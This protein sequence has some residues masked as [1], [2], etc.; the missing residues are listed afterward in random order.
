MMS[1]FVRKLYSTLSDSV[2]YHIGGERISIQHVA[3]QTSSPTA[4][5]REESVF[6]SDN[7][8]IFTSTRC[9]ASC[10]FTF[11]YVRMWSSSKRNKQSRR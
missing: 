3:V 11:L 7:P 6:Y 5:K 10:V 2:K 1:S 9:Y 4:K 8:Y